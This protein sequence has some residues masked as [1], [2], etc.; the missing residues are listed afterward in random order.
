MLLCWVSL[1]LMSRH[2]FPSLLP[3]LHLCL[4]L[5]FLIFILFWWN[6]FFC[7]GHRHLRKD[8]LIMACTT[9]LFVSFVL[10]VAAAKKGKRLGRCGTSSGHTTKIK[11]SIIFRYLWS[12]VRQTLLVGTK[13]RQSR[14]R[15]YSNCLGGARG[16]ACSL[17][18]SSYLSCS[19]QLS[20]CVIRSEV[21]SG[22][23]FWCFVRDV[24][25]IALW[26]Y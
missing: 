12:W 6:C 4:Y 16:E 9:C 18:C 1:C 7:F 23:L 22:L 24:P 26:Y 2:P 8:R 19:C 25:Q 11:Q 13:E 20:G 14:G 15:F 21:G 10:L 3:F 17:C 5:S